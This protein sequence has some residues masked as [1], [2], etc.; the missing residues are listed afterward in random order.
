MAIFTAAMLFLLHNKLDHMN[1]LIL[2]IIAIYFFLFL[3]IWN[4]YLYIKN[5]Q[6]INL[7]SALFSGFL[8]SFLVS[9]FNGKYYLGGCILLFDSPSLQFLVSIAELIDFIIAGSF[10][11][12]I[13]PLPFIKNK[14][15]RKIL[16]FC[17]IYVLIFGFTFFAAGYFRD[18]LGLFSLFY[19][20]E[21]V[22][23]IQ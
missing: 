16:L 13:L 19:S 23:L 21:P 5:N 18:S 17:G 9:V 10:F 20:C 7:I 2:T 14:T 12:L 6:G 11:L 4:L 3:A 8:F 22:P 15:Y 1:L